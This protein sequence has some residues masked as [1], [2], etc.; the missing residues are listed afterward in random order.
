MY[1]FVVNEKS[2]NGRGQ[3]IWAKVEAQLRLR[4]I[5]YLKVAAQS[6]EEALTRVEELLAGYKL[7]A[8]AVIGGDG[9]IHGLLSLLS[10]SNVPIG[11]IPSGSGNDTSRA[12][13]IPHNP[14]QALNIILAGHTRTL[15]LLETNAVGRAGQQSFTAVAIGLD[16][17]V[18]ED[19]NSSSYKSWCNKLRMGSLAYVIGLFRAL[20]T[21]KPQ[22]LTITVDGITQEFQRGWLAAV[23]NISTYGGG[24]QICP[25]ALADDGRLHVCIVHGCSVWR[26]LLLFPTILNGSHVKQPYVTILTGN[27]VTIQAPEPLLAYGDGEPS[28]LTPVTAAIRPGQLLFLTA[29]SG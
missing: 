29:V 10:N 18:A 1:L 14:V 17:A 8:I 26:I 16:G 2:G 13:G 5:S 22:T 21:F 27:T 9:T 19:V 6:Q 11:L 25:K 12:L 4:A 23:A 20:T 7:K 28:G 15:D 3:K 24:L